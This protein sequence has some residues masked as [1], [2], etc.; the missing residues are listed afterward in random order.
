MGRL[1]EFFKALGGEKKRPELEVLESVEDYVAVGDF[2]RAIEAANSLESE[3]NR[4]LAARI[5][6]R[7]VLKRLEKDSEELTDVREIFQEIVPLINSITNPRHR[8]LLTFDLALI[9][10]YLGDEFKG[11]LTLKTA[12]NL[13]KGY[14]DILLDMV[15]ELVR[16]GLL[17]KA[18]GALKMVRDRDKLDSVLVTIAEIFYRMGDVERA[19]NVIRHIKNPFHKSMALYYLALIESSRDRD[20]ALT[21]LQAAV[22]V[23]EKIENPDARFELMLKLY[24]LK[25]SLEGHSV[26]LVDVLTRRESHQE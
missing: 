25:N 9:L 1:D 18:S 12:L 13:A 21:L 15:R 11:D 2:G 26:S 3:R 16:R 20:T 24:D 22:K 10:Y 14:D 7:E 8:A 23:A 6:L 5:I 4:F 17:E 19:K